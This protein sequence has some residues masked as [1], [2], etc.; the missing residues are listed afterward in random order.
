MMIYTLTTMRPFKVGYYRY[1]SK[2][3]TKG[4]ELN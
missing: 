4:Q 1:E 2:I 3:Q